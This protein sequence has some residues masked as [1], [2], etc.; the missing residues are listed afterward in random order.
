MR[1]NHRFVRGAQ[2]LLGESLA[3]RQRYRDADSVLRAVLA[4]E[5]DTPAWPNLDRARTLQALGTERRAAGD[6]AGAE[7]L[8][9][10]VLAI[11]RRVQSR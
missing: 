5:P 8:L 6:T 9:R 4:L 3:R 7:R 11:R 1:P 2:R 10:E